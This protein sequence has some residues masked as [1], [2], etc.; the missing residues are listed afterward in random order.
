MG[1]PGQ[2]I[3]GEAT[4]IPGGEPL[5]LASLPPT[6]PVGTGPSVSTAALPYGEGDY[7]TVNFDL[8]SDDDSQEPAPAGNPAPPVNAEVTQWAAEQ[9][10]EGTDDVSDVD[11]D[12]ALTDAALSHVQ[13]LR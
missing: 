11:E 6:G 10:A 4:S 12:F 8:N 7:D 1:I 13:E 9:S 5:P 2:G 3:R